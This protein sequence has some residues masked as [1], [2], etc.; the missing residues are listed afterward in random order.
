MF[1]HSIIYKR[2]TFTQF[3]MSKIINNSFIVI[4][5]SSSVYSCVPLSRYEEQESEL[6]SL[7]RKY[8]DLEDSYRSLENK[9]KALIVEYNDL[10]E[11]YNTLVEQRNQFDYRAISHRYGYNEYSYAFTVRSGH[12]T[13]TYKSPDGN[14]AGSFGCNNSV[15]GDTITS[16]CV[17]VAQWNFALMW[18]WDIEQGGERNYNPVHLRW[19][20]EA[21]AAS[22]DAF[23]EHDDCS[24]SAKERV[25][26]YY[27]SLSRAKSIGGNTLWETICLTR[28]RMS[29]NPLIVEN[30]YNYD[31]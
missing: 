25:Y 27:Q 22:F 20:I 21:L 28:F 15:S 3:L 6:L 5:I 8:T 9:Y 13:W 7:E 16:D 11:K 12:V 24:S 10:V 18:L 31:F 14:Y 1:L 30:L 17:G 23:S 19:A 4:L 29:E 2:N 26:E